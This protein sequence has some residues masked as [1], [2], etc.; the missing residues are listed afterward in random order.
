MIGRI[1]TRTARGLAPYPVPAGLEGT[2]ACATEDP[3]RFFP[4][5]GTSGD[6]HRQTKD[7]CRRCPFV[8]GCLAYAIDRP[9]LVGIWGATSQKERERL[10]RGKRV[11]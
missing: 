6:P 11:A 1:G 5:A 7:I 2:Q 10:R 4:E 8:T 9:A 3:D